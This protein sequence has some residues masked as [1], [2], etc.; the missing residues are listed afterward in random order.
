M[1]DPL[2]P[3]DGWS[4]LHPSEILPGS[5]N[6]LGS[7]RMRI[8]TLVLAARAVPHRTVHRDGGWAILVP[9]QE[10][11]RA[12]QEIRVYEEKNRFWPP[13]QPAGNHQHD[14]SLQALSCLLVLAIFHNLTLL[15]SGFLGVYP[16]Q[17]LEQGAAHAA[18]IRNGQWWRALT[19]LTLHVDWLHL[20]GNL[21]LG[22]V[23]A[24]RLCALLG[25]GWGL[26]LILGAGFLGNLINAW[27]QLGSHR[28]VGASTALFG[29]IGILC[30]LAMR[31]KK[32]T[33]RLR[34]LLPLAA[35]AALLAMFGAGG[36]NTDLGAHLFGLLAGMLLGALLPSRYLQAQPCNLPYGRLAGLAA[37]TL[38]V[39]AWILALRPVF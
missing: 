33:S 15:D 29:T 9:E 36:E 19:A 5:D 22:G 12:E 14:N 23:F 34:R 6:I 16:H 18:S 11:W 35:G 37:P 28:A 4:R 31:Q 10:R 21:A 32:T 27:M 1:D 39:T 3:E 8:W 7:A 13:R 38:L 30:V 24:V 2:E 26:T 17:W 20:A 25:L